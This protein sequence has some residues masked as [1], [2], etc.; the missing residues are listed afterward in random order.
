MRYKNKYFNI[1]NLDYY[2]KESEVIGNY[3][4]FTKTSI[5]QSR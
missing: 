5:N 2:K 4:D 1:H 3:A